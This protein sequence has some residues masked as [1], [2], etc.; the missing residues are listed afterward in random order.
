MKANF[1]LSD[2]QRFNG[3]RECS[4]Y[5]KQCEV[6]HIRLRNYFRKTGRR[7]YGKRSSS[8][9]KWS[10]DEFVAEFSCSSRFVCLCRIWKKLAKFDNIKSLMYT[11]AFYALTHRKIADYVTDVNN[12]QWISFQSIV[13]E[14]KYNTN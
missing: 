3:R 7:L 11:W 9:H 6:S 12:T 2:F 1:C 13:Q 5:H 8:A 10:G 4:I 14:K